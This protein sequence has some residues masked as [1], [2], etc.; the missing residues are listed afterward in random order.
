MHEAADCGGRARPG[1]GPAKLFR[2][3]LF[4]IDTVSNGADAY[5]YAQSGGYDALILDVMMPKLNGL[6]VVRQLRA[7][8]FAGPIMLLTARGE[9]S[10]SRRT[11]RRKK[12]IG[13]YLRRARRKLC[14]AL[15]PIRAKPPSVL[16]RWLCFLGRVRV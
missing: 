7:Q 15:G 14:E 16:L 5:A 12:Q 8:G 1:R 10:F 11:R 2:E 4:T 9:K 6:A 13:P 3:K